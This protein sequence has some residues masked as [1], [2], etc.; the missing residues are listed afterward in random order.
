MVL[1]ILLYGFVCAMSARHVN[2]HSE[3]RSRWNI[4]KSSHSV[5][6]KSGQLYFKICN[7]RRDL[8][9][10]TLILKVKHKVWPG[11]M[12]LL[13]LQESLA[14]LHQSWPPYSGIP[15]ELHCLTIWNMTELLQ[16]HT[17]LIGKRRAALK[18]KRRG[19]LRHHVLFHQDN[20]PVHTS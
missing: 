15:M 2:R 13:H 19:K 1:V 18:E 4:R 7:R 3:S 20:A 16:E 5:Q 17:T 6:R 14:C 10:P 9:S 11:N 8:A 12:S